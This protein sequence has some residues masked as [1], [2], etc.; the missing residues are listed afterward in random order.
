MV[1]PLKHIVT[2]T[3]TQN[4]KHHQ[5]QIHPLHM[6]AVTFPAQ[7]VDLS[8][9]TGSR[10]LLSLESMDLVALVS[11]S[12]IFSKESVVNHVHHLGKSTLFNVV[13]P[14]ARKSG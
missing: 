9:L 7:A 11:S 14:L 10:Q 4:K 6:I 1:A 13:Q 12:Y 2:V 3:L 5:R 8:Q